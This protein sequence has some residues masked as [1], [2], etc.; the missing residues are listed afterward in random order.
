MPVA[1]R[2]SARLKKLQNDRAETVARMGAMLDEAGDANLNDEQAKEYAALEGE[3]KT[4]DAR[5]DREEK[6]LEAQSKSGKVIKSLAGDGTGDQGSALDRAPAAAKKTIVGKIHDNQADDPSYGF[7][8]PREFLM[9]VMGAAVMQE[10]GL[11]PDP[12]LAPL[13]AQAIDAK[14]YEQF[15]RHMGMTAGSD[16]QQTQAD[17]YGGYLVPEA[18]LPQFLYI[19][20]E[21]DPITD[22][23]KVPMASPIVN[24]P[25]RTDKNHT[26]SVAGGIIVTRKMETNTAISSLMNMQKIQMQAYALFGLSYCTEEILVDSPISFAAII[27]QGFSQAFASQLINEKLYGSGVGEYLGVMNSAALITQAAVEDQAADTIVIQNVLGMR[28]RCWGYKNAVWVANHDTL[29]QIAQ[30]SLPNTSGPTAVLV[31]MPSS[32]ED[33]PDRL[34]GRPIYFSEYAQ[35]LGSQGDIGL[36]N[37]SQFLEGTYQ[38]L[39]RA[40]SVHVRFLNHERTFKFWTRNCGAPWWN[41]PLTPM[42][43]SNTLSPFVTLAERG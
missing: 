32:G 23:T 35:S 24:I 29:P 22:T 36:F 34:L 15:G 19:E 12:R 42:Y 39:Q 40:E 31:F 11:R 18:F 20:P 6:F 8:T 9:A 4:I 1:V 16:E 33:V 43:S 3:L 13:S 2:E 30:L 26:Q 10:A 5:I 25:A 17:Q 28:S 38:P 14:W 21:D 27:S 37:M 41:A 7:K